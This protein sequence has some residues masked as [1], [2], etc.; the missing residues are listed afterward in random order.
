MQDR[1]EKGRGGEGK[2]E[3]DGRERKDGG[4]GRGCAVVKIP[5][6]AL[7]FLNFFSV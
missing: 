1:E 3:K 4:E 2:G 5:L 7:Q 6:K